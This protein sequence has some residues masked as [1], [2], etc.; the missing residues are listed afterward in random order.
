MTIAAF[1][2][3][4]M[5][6]AIAVAMEADRDRLCQ[7]DGVIGDADHGIAMALGFNAARD[8]L[9]SLDLTAAEPTAL[10]NAAAKSFLNAVGASCGP[11]YATAF[12]RAAAAVK[13]KATLADADVVALLQAMAQ[14]IKDRGKAETGEKTMVD[15]WQ[16]AAEAAGAS[17]AAGKNLAESLQAAFAAAER[18]AESTKD[19]I[20]A[21]GR[22]S[23]L[24]ERSLGHI[25]P[26]AASAVTVIGAMRDSLA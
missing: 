3:K 4:R 20:A 17:N 10:L 26:G 1:D 19:M 6:D 25:D 7:L 14:G 18:G 11:L 9:A 5:F 22:S 21:K 15:A 8:A 13:G 12:M 23:R 2:L 24:G 16:P